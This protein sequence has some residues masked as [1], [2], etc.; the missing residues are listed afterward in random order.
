MTAGIQIT[1]ATF[2][3]GSTI[4][5]DD[6][7]PNISINRWDI[8][9]RGFSGGGVAY[10][11]NPTVFESWTVDPGTTIASAIYFEATGQS[12]LDIWLAKFSNAGFDINYTYAYNATWGAGSTTVNTVVRV[13]VGINGTGTGDPNLMKIIPIDTTVTGWQTNSVFST[14][15]LPGTYNF[16]VALTPYVPTTQMT[17]NWT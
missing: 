16:P 11:G 13:G 2:T 8:T 3:N 10:V 14:L 4:L 17:T 6:A 9:N 15:A 7:S 5:G 12:T 1:G